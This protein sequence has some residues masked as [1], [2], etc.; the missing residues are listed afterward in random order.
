MP[1]EST[2]TAAQAAAL[3]GEPKRRFVQSVFD[4]LAPRYDGINLVISL[5]QTSLWR[6]AALSGLDLAPGQ[7]ALDVGCG[8]G[9]TVRHLR[10]RYP[11]T[12]IEGM[13]LSPG[14]VAEARRRDPEGS[15]FEGD[16]GAVDRPDASYDLVTTVYTSRN[17]PDLDRALAEMTRLLRP[18]G[19]LLLLD[20]FPPPGPPI[21]RAFHAFWMRRAIPTLVRPFADRASFAYLA[22]SVLAHV[23]PQEIVSR[24]G[25]LGCRAET[26]SYSL[27]T[28]WRI[29]GVRDQLPG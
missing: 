20:V 26:R 16:A 14:M 8:T 24:L 18:G 9:W 17:F 29:L 3:R 19:R 23:S 11:G 27:G 13:D 15:Y 4:R 28:A 10:R 5:G 22:E 2:L 6:R 1:T 7:R 25:K 21:W 12:L